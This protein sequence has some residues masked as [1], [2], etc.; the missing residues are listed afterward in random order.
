M[1]NE[2]YDARLSELHEKN[3]LF[4]ERRVFHGINQYPIAQFIDN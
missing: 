4:F 2:C 1:Q 3:R